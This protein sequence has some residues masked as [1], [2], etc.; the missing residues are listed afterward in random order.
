MKITAQYLNHHLI[1]T[2]KNFIFKLIYLHKFFYF[3]F[4]VIRLIII[5]I[6]RL[7]QNLEAKTLYLHNYLIDLLKIKI[8]EAKYICKLNYKF[9]KNI[10]K[11]WLR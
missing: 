3:N 11:W 5:K 7:E 4:K 9:L 1:I 10:I 6:W 8:K 2:S